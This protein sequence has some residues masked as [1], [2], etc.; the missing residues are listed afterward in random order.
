MQLGLSTGNLYKFQKIRNSKQEIDLYSKAGVEGIE[1]FTRKFP[2]LDGL[3]KIDSEW[4][5]S[6]SYKSIHAPGKQEYKNDK[7]TK[8][9]LEKM[10]KAVKALEIQ[11]VVLHPEVVLDWEVFAEFSD[12]PFAVEN[13]D[14]RKFFGKFPDELVE[15]IKKYNFGFVL[16]FQHIYM[17]DRSMELADEFM[18]KFGE[19][20]VEVHVSGAAEDPVHEMLYKTKQD[21]I[22]KALKGVLQ[23]KDVPVIIESNFEDEEDIERELKYIRTH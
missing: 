5:E 7:S 10:R 14:N 15:I 23:K 16:D 3:A 18:D 22:I 20:L 8:S 4:L 1:L 17:N 11:T 2:D 9:A 21:V 19:S 12:I 6:F 13:M